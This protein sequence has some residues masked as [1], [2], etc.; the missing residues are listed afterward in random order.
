MRPDEV[1]DNRYFGMFPKL[2]KFIGLWPYQDRSTKYLRRIA[3]MFIIH[4]MMIPQI[5]R[6]IEEFYKPQRDVVIILENM[7]GFVYFQV[8]LMKMYVSIFAEKK[9][10]HLYEEITHDFGAIV[11]GGER[12]TIRHSWKTIRLL[13]LFYSG[14]YVE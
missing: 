12:D 7:A 3:V 1:F 14:M 10:I 11:D 5:I 13:Y 6:G 8:V 2:L 4:T 9:L